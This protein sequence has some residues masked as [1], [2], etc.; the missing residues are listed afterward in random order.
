MKYSLLHPG[1]ALVAALLLGVTAITAQANVTMQLDRSDIGSDET[2]ELTVNSSGSGNNSVAAPN[3]PGLQFTAVSQSSQIEIINGNASSTSSVTY[4]ITP[5]GPGSYTIP[6]PDPTAAKLTLRVHAGSGAGSANA[7]QTAVSP[8]TTA[9]PAPALPT[10]AIPGATPGAPN[11]TANGAAFMRMQMS[12]HDLY[13]GENVPVDIQIGL[14]AGMAAS[15]QG[16]PTLSADAFTLN[17]LTDKPEQTEEVINGQPYTILTWHSVLAAV[18]PG[19]FSLTAQSPVTV[20]IRTAAPRLPGNM[21]DMFNDPF[22]QNLFG[23]GVTQKELNLT[24]D[25]VAIKVQPLPSSGQPANFSGAVGN[26][27]ASSELSATSGTVGDPLTLRLKINGSGAFDRVESPMLGSVDGWKTYR[28]TGK[29]V[30]TDSIGYSGE[31]DF[32]Q[33]VIPQR[34]G[35]QTVPPINFSYFNPETGRYEELHTV[36]I[37]VEFEPGS[38]PVAATNPVAPPTQPATA[39]TPAPA[40]VGLRPDM[41]EAG[42]TIRTL[43]PLYFQ[44]EFLLAQAA[45]ALA[46]VGAG[47]GLR[48]NRQFASDP[49]RIKRHQELKAVDALLAQMDSAANQQDA[50]TFFSSARQALQHALASRWK[51]TPRA[52]TLAEIEKHSTSGNENLRQVFALADELAY[53]GGAGI[54][55]DFSAWKQTVHQ[56]IKQ[57]ETV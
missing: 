18:K 50:A 11:M 5:Q 17:K 19:D 48:F 33:A 6:S 30:P 55:A 8:A 35:H 39:A 32:E 12:K 7:P 27:S 24:T 31:K 34:P 37:N 36:A 1:R 43:R 14:R 46:F 15:L 42:T 10:P 25:A 54:D 53:S 29:F 9:S 38:A 51:M 28:P 40:P 4:E 13:V 2:A 16:L 44:P 57:T 52:I 21:G 20:Q 23:G 41:T 3:V 22:F 47:F 45:L 56:L 26:F 49:T